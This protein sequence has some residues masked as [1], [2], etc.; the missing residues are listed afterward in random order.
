MGGWAAL[1][2]WLSQGYFWD[3]LIF[4]LL[5][6][7]FIPALPVYLSPLPALQGPNSE[8]PVGPGRLGH[9]AARG[10]S[11]NQGMGPAGRGA[12][13]TLNSRATFS[14]VASPKHTPTSVHSTETTQAVIHFSHKESSR[15]MWEWG[16]LSKPRP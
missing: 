14:R 4:W 7:L 12:S 11:P 1:T 15:L 13:P 6:S 16:D 2:F 5:S 3:H 9:G 10:D 8:H